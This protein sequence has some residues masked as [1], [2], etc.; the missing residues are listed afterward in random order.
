MF[1]KDWESNLVLQLPWLLSPAFT[2]AFLL[3]G[4]MCLIFEGGGNS[5]AF[6][7]F[8]TL[9]KWSVLIF[10]AFILSQVLNNSK[11]SENIQFLSTRKVFSSLLRRLSFLS[12]LEHLFPSALNGS[13]TDVFLNEYICFNTIRQNFN[14][15]LSNNEGSDKNPCVHGKCLLPTCTMCH[16]PGKQGCCGNPSV[17]LTAQRDPCTFPCPRAFLS[18]PYSSPAASSVMFFLIR[19][20]LSL[21][22]AS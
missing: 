8:F 10:T 4:F 15:A 21:H 3:M 18:Q 14:K 12:P 22:I 20:F 7:V 1:I 9:Y 5:L 11:S 16:P 13:L 19:W 2:V 6:C 17:S